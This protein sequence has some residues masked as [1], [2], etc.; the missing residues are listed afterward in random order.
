MTRPRKQIVDYFPHDT[1]ASQ[2]RTLSVLQNKYGNDGYAFWFQLLELLGRSPGHF[3]NFKEVTDWEFL[4]AR[5]HISRPETA[6]SILETLATMNAINLE[7]YE[8]GIIWS[9]NFVDRLADVYVRRK[10]NKPGKP[11]SAAE[12]PISSAGMP[13]SA[14]SN[15]QSKVKERKVNNTPKGG[16]RKAPSSTKEEKKDS[17]INEIFAEMRSYLGFPGKVKI[18][19]IPSYG[20]EGQAIKRMFTRGFTREEILACWKGKVSQ[21]GGEFV[22]MTW[23]NQDIGTTGTGKQKRVSRE[24]ST[25]E[26]IAESIRGLA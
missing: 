1:D 13:V 25:A 9:Q 17:V 22:S 11:V 20:K 4:L 3:Y 8:Q 15:P 2:G 10:E 21:R 23:V 7:L 12:T 19:P 16:Q 14:I 6:R 18:D 26:E 24:P 5:T